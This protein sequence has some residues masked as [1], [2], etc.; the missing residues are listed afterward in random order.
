[1]DIHDAISYFLEEA[2]NELRQTDQDYR[3]V[4]TLENH[5][6]TQLSEAAG[7]EL[8]EKLNEAQAERMETD[9][10]RSF[11][12]GLRLGADLHRL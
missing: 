6:L 12:W 11:L 7:E 9:R 2:L 10:L 5:L 8:V 3:A 4:R 1:M